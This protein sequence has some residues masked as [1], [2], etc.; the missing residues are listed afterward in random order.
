MVKRGSA[1]RVSDERLK[2]GAILD[3]DVKIIRDTC[4]ALALGEKASV[5]RNYRYHGK[6]PTMIIARVIRLYRV[7]RTAVPRCS[8]LVGMSK[9]LKEVEP[10]Q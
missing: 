10:R 2:S 7:A 9:T 6:A 3:R 4:D 5:C 1:Y 8:A